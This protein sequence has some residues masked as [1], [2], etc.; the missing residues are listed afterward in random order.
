MDQ[1]KKS[2]PRVRFFFCNKKL[3]AECVGGALRSAAK[4]ESWQV[5][6]YPDCVSDAR[7]ACGEK[8]T[9]DVVTWLSGGVRPTKNMVVVLVMKTSKLEDARFQ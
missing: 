3:F 6:V 2:L 8:F 5:T 7:R 4:M 9:S 1:S